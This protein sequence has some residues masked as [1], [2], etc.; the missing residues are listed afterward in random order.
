MALALR[1]LGEVAERF[2]NGSLYADLALSTGQPVAPEDVL[3]YFLRALGVAPQRVPPGLAERTALYR[4]VTAQLD[5]VVLLD[6]A[7]S[8]AQAKVLL[9][10]APNSL[11]V[12]TSRRPLLGLVATGAHAVQVDPLAAVCRSRSA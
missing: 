1:W 2:P 7:A 6:N 5:L 11:A 8:A 3:G 4:S 12:V 10:V 9:P